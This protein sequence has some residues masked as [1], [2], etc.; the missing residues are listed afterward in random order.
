MISSELE[1]VGKYSNTAAITAMFI[2]WH[3]QRYCNVAVLIC[4]IFPLVQNQPFVAIRI[5]PLRAR[6]H[7][8]I[9]R[10]LQEPDQA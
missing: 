6:S 8:V 9:G 5:S 3:P 7:T 10:S 4:S 1:L 2:A